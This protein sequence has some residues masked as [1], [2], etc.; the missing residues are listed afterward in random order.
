M[1]CKPSG[2]ALGR[3]QRAP[4]SSQAA[5][6]TRIV[7]CTVTL[8]PSFLS[9]STMACLLRG[10]QQQGETR[11]S[12]PKTQA[13]ARRHHYGMQA[14][15]GSVRRRPETAIEGKACTYAPRQLRPGQHPACSP[16]QLKV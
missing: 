6:L 3:G 13:D 16:R 5:L 4:E 1:P 15:G 14:A 8:P 9:A 10:G 7:S 11:G 2:P 12:G